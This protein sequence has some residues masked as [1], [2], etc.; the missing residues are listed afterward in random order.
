MY[1]SRLEFATIYLYKHFRIFH[2]RT[3]RVYTAASQTRS[4]LA[5]R[6]RVR[7]NLKATSARSFSSSASTIRQWAYVNSRSKND[8]LRLRSC[9]VF[10]IGVSTVSLLGLFL[11]PE[12]L[13]PPRNIRGDDL[14]IVDPSLPFQWRKVG[15]HADLK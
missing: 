15:P 14:P 13:F 1:M 7:P 3:C 12:I 8:M 6:I 9:L 2:L 5:V 10:I 11:H 4:M